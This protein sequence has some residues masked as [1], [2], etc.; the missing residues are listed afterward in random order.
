MKRISISSSDQN[1]VV[2]AE[3]YSNLIWFQY[4]G[5][6]YFIS[7]NK[8]LSVK[9][10]KTDSEKKDRKKHILSDIPGQVV[11]VL[12]SEGQQ[13]TENQALL[14][15]SSMKM[16]YTL[17]APYNSQVK[18][19]KVQEGDVVAVGQELILFSDIAS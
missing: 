10:N 11:K 18:A 19:I 17:K 1:I 6:I 16:E 4:E 14:V 8:M 9:D 5:F 3:K 15:L 2:K 7:S 13:V 12:V